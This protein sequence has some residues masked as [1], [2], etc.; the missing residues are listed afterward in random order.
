MKEGLV[1]DES[2]RRT[3]AKFIMHY[4]ERDYFCVKMRAIKGRKRTSAK[5]Q[6]FAPSN[7]DH[8][9]FSLLKTHKTKESNIGHR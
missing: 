9:F 6:Q 4:I 5:A 7:A 1:D 3:S 2:Q 8:F